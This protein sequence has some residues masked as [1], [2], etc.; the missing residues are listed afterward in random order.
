MILTYKFEI[1]NRN[2]CGSRFE[3]GYR[4]IED[5]SPVLGMP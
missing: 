1:D 5:E 4:E 2:E 3:V